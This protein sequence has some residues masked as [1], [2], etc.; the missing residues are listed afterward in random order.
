MLYKHIAFSGMVLAALALLPPA[1]LGAETK[2]H[3]DASGA[4]MQP[5]Y[6]ETALA[7]RE[8]GAAVISALVKSDGTVRR[9]ALL[10]SSGYSDLD[11]AAANAVH[12]WKFVPATDD[13][14][15][16]E[17]WANVQIVF[18]PPA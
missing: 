13:G 3:V 15:P 1:A 11:N 9:V 17:G 14:K 4:N 12:G 18:T 8:Q 10:R 2:P 7:A 6:P 16:V 5:A